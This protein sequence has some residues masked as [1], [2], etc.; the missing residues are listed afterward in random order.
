MAECVIS[1]SQ[2]IFQRIHDTVKLRTKIS[3][4][5]T[6]VQRYM[7]VIVIRADRWM[8][9]RRTTDEIQFHDLGQQSQAERKK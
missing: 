1:K 8:D 6:Q 3:K 5:S 4:K 9:E 7:H 2:N